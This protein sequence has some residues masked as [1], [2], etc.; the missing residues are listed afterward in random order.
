MRMFVISLESYRGNQA[1]KLRFQ[2]TQEFVCP[3]NGAGKWFPRG[4][5]PAS[6]WVFIDNIHRELHRNFL[7]ST[8]EF[9]FR[10]LREVPSNANA[11]LPQFTNNC[12][13]FFWTYAFLFFFMGLLFPQ[14]DCQFHEGKFYTFYFKLWLLKF[15]ALSDSNHLIRV[16]ND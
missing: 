12:T 10:V 1:M 3:A 8:Q 13:A 16:R 15:I 4:G 2:V 14:F 7:K 9:V 11:Q 6:P 5:K